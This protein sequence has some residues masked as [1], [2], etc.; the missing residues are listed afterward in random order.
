MFFNRF[1]SKSFFIYISIF[2]LLPTSATLF[3]QTQPVSRETIQIGPTTLQVPK[4]WRP[5]SPKQ[6]SFDNGDYQLVAY[7][8]SFSRGELIYLEILPKSENQTNN[9]ESNP[10]T[11]HELIHIGLTRHSVPLHKFSEGFQAMFLV[12][13]D[14]TKDSYLTWTQKSKAG[15][16]TEVIRI[17]INLHKFPE[18]TSVLPFAKEYADPNQAQAAQNAKR[19]AEERAIKNRAFAANSDWSFT[20]QLSHPRDLHYLTSVFY[21]SRLNQRYKEEN[22]KRIFMPP[23]RSVHRGTDFRGVTGAPIFAVAPGTVVLAQQMY[24]EGGFTL[25]DHGNGIKIGYMHQSRIHVK[26]GD[27]IQ[28]GQVIGDVGATGMVTGSHLHLSVW[29]NG[30]PGDAL[31]LFSLPLR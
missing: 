2:V 4:G 7:S 15:P 24:Y 21:S 9:Q 6:L 25:V 8:R 18:S 28:A 23:Q 10:I 31:S 14:Q 12:S 19:I 26:V 29:V 27:K 1:L 20:N 22:G 17:P 11:T 30:I 16:R 3:S 13:P 5:P